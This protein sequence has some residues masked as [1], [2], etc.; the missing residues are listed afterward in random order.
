MLDPKNHNDLKLLEKCRQINKEIV[1]FGVNDK[2]IIKIIELLSFEL[3]DT[4]LMRSINSVL[5]NEPEDIE[6]ENIVI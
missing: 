1:S 5:K 3:E 4:D 6:K 2:E